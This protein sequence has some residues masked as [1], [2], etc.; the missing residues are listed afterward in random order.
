MNAPDLDRLAAGRPG[1]QVYVEQEP[2]LGEAT[3]TVLDPDGDLDT[4]HRWV[5][6]PHAGFWGL[7][8]LSRTE[9][10]ELYAYVDSLPSHHAFLIRFGGVPVVLLQTYQ[11]ECDPVGECYPVEP[12]DVG[13]HF[14]LGA[15]S[16]R[17]PGYTGR[18]AA[19]V[20]R[21]LFSRPGAQRIIG[22]PDIRNR[23]AVERLTRLGFQ[24]G[25]EIDLPDKRA[26]LAFLT[27]S[28]WE[29]TT[30]H[31]DLPGEIVVS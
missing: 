4:I 19:L 24:L 16:R 6:E 22:E 2:E 11:P 9:L 25:P 12:G 1:E 5:R 13:V 23:P 21:F 26:Q 29:S 18:I 31:P 27:R 3:V 30:T 15:R 8:G 10:R 28:R 20:A 7:A 17:I 14:L